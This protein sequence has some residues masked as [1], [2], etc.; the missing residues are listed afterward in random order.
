MIAETSLSSTRSESD[1]M[2]RKVIRYI[3]EKSEYVVFKQEPS[4]QIFVDIYKQYAPR[5]KINMQ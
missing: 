3:E 2:Q 1:N 5:I 4:G